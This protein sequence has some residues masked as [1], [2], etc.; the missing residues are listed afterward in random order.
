MAVV[1]QVVQPGTT[2]KLRVEMTTDPAQTGRSG[3]FVLQEA[4]LDA[5]GTVTDLTVSDDWVT[6]AMIERAFRPTGAATAAVTATPVFSSASGPSGEDAWVV[7]VD[8]TIGFEV[9]DLV[10]AAEK[11][12]SAGRTHSV[13]AIPDGTSLQLHGSSTAFDIADGDDIEQVTGTGVYAGLFEFDVDAHMNA[14]HPDAQL[15]VLIE[16]TA[17]GDT[18]KFDTAAVLAWTFDL[19]LD[20]GSRQYRAG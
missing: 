3:A 10:R 7:T 17:T 16:T 11:A 14:A 6:P 13:L 9:G 18:P 15:R 4:I 20:L 2:A 12:D 5:D 8:S 1:R 19:S